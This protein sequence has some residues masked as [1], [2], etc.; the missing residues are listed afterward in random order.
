MYR[1]SVENP[2]RCFIRDGMIEEQEFDTKAEAKE[3]AE[4]MLKKMQDDFCKKHD[5]NLSEHLGDFTIRI[6]SR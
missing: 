3:V 2:C 4:A 6:S 5:F 1:V